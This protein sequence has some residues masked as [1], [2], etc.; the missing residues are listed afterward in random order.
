MFHVA[1]RILLWCATS[2]DRRERAI[3][4]H[5]QPPFYRMATVAM[6]ESGVNHKTFIVSSN[7]ARARFTKSSLA[8]SDVQATTPG[9]ASAWSDGFK[10]FFRSQAFPSRPDAKR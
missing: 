7:I 5:C 9:E 2:W 3:K 6:S 10:Y 4:Q 1:L 8:A